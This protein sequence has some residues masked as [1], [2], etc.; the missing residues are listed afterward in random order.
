MMVT[1]TRAEM[2]RENQELRARLSLNSLRTID[3]W[4]A[5]PVFFKAERP[6]KPKVA[7]SILAGRTNLYL[8][9]LIV[10]PNGSSTPVLMLPI[11]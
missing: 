1:M 8:P 10:T 9:R 4:E 3:E 6:P 7:S 11:A 2:R 5:L